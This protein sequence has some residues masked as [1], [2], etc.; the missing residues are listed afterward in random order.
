MRVEIGEK[1]PLTEPLEDR[2]YAAESLLGLDRGF[3]RP[4]HLVSGT[5]PGKYLI[6]QVVHEASHSALGRQ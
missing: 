1:A 3:S 2:D 6:F 5:E 4:E